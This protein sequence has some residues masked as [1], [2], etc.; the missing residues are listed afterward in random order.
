MEFGL[1]GNLF[2]SEYFS[3]LLNIQYNKQ[4]LPL[5][6]EVDN[7]EMEKKIGI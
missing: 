2:V 4:K 6:W 7:L 1:N 5:M 3:N